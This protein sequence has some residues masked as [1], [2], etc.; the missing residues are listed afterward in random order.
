MR[1]RHLFKPFLVMCFGAWS[2]GT[3]A[4]AAET[5]LPVAVL[6]EDARVDAL[7][8]AVPAGIGQALTD[9]G[10]SVRPADTAVFEADILAK[11]D[12]LLLVLPYGGLYPAASAKS[13]DAF[14]RQGGSLICVW[15][16]PFSEPV[17]AK[18]GNVH[19]LTAGTAREAAIPL[20]PPWPKGHASTGVAFR[21]EPAEDGMSAQ[22]SVDGFS[23]YGYIGTT[24]PELAFEIGRAHV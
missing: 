13:L 15:G 12:A 10:Y 5:A 23:G 6:W 11:A 18:A 7:A 19:Y 2:V 21:M 8:G 20:T 1:L 9:A 22:V 14:L 16:A 3:L 4:V 24:P 17:F